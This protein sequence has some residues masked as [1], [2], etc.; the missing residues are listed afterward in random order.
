MVT[1]ALRNG[2][3]P[4][5]N[6]LYNQGYREY[7]KNK[8][9]MQFNEEEREY[10]KKTSSVPLAA[11]YFNYPGDFYN[12]YEKKWEGIVFDV[13][14][15]VEELTGLKFEVVNNTSTELSDLFDMVYD[16][17][18]HIMPELIYSESRAQYVIWTK[19]IFL[20]DQLALL[21]K[22]TYPN[23]S[24]NEI[25]YKRIGVIANTV[26]AEM[27]RTWFPIAENITEYNTDENAMR[28]LEQGEIDLVMSSKNRLLSFLNF[29]DT[30]LFNAN[31][32][33]N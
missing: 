22:S 8:L 21:S 27:F 13:L 33:F 25:P 26:R 14:S 30:S 6:Y 24:A 32:I 7:K 29:Q 3:K 16:G 20:A 31:F 28:A 23:V 17:R 4:Y 11:R 10:L 5:L 18:A 15:E 2:A 12:T 19:H 9:F 1:K